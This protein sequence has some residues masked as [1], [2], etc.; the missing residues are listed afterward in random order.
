MLTLE[1]FDDRND[2]AG[3]AETK[4]RKESPH[5]AGIGGQTPYSEEDAR[6]IRA[7]RGDHREMFAIRPSHALY[8]S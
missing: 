2:V 8:R 7:C 6:V 1:T 4:H 5:T 3:L